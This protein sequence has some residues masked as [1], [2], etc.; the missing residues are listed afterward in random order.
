MCVCVRV[1]V[2][3]CVHAYSMV[4]I[5]LASGGCMGLLV[6]GS[7]GG[8]VCGWMGLWLDGSVGGWVCGW[9]KG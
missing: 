8:W 5:T 9:V 6:N 4:A 3:M 7:M 2:R 1:R